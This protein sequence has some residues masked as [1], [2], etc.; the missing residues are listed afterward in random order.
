MDIDCAIRVINLGN[1]H[2]VKVEASLK[3]YWFLQIYGFSQVNGKFGNGQPHHR[4][5]AAIIS[6][7][8]TPAYPIDRVYGLQSH[9]SL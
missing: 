4:L 3:F 2:R 9:I 1:I 7:D 6:I 5:I 8:C